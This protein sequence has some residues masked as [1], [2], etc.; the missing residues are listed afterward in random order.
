MADPKQQAGQHGRTLIS[1]TFPELPRYNRT[2]RW[3]VG[4]SVLGVA[5]LAW[6][7]YDRNLLFA[8]IVL[9]VLAIVFFQSRR[10]PNTLTTN[11]TEDG[12]EIGRDFFSYDDIAKFWIIYKPPQVKTFY[13]R[14]KSALRPI[15]GIP[16]ENTNPVKLREQLLRFLQEDLEQE[17]E[18]ASDA[19]G[20]LFKI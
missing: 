13:L 2:R 3:Y 5:L 16:L 14:F 12:L 1:W 20:R 9:L 7:F 17:E 19:Y 4:M 8:I 6:S 10:E 18:P 15:L 11:V